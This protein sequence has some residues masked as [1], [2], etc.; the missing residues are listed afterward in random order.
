VVLDAPARVVP[1]GRTVVP[2]RFVSESMGADVEWFR[3]G[4]MVAVNEQ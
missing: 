1:P 4:Q 3:M 2:L